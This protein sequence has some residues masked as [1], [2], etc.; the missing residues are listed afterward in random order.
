MEGFESRFD[1]IRFMFCTFTVVAI[2][3]FVSLE[4]IKQFAAL[5]YQI[6]F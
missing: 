5:I 4:I 6:Y 3:G 1:F 2:L